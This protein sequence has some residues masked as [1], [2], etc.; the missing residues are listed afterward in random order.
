MTLTN[1][2]R[3]NAD[4]EL[5]GYR[6]GLLC[7]LL[8]LT[9][10]LCGLVPAARVLDPFQ[11]FDA[12]LARQPYFAAHLLKSALIALGGL[13]A[14]YILFRLGSHLKSEHPISRR[15][16]QILVLTGLGAAVAVVVA[17]IA[18]SAFGTHG[19]FYQGRCICGH[20]IFVRIQGDGYY[21]Y[22]PGH[23]ESEHRAFAVRRR[24]D[25]WD[26]FRPPD[27]AMFRYPSEPEDKVLA[28]IRLGDGALYE[29]W[30]TGTNWQRLPRVYNIWRVWAAKLLQE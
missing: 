23:G 22:S 20:D 27:S 12:T 24:G 7:Q 16:R 29:S 15:A 19:Y 6:V 5:R 17:P 10:A 9:I 8:A 13:G 21:S 28:R 11:G 14:G 4:N 30:G 3:G 18:W 26:V 25:E 2:H 1:P